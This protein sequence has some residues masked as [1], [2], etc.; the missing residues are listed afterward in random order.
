MRSRAIPVCPLGI[1][2]ILTLLSLRCNKSRLGSLNRPSWTYA[3]WR[4]LKTPGGR[5]PA[6]N[7]PHSET[8][9][10]TMKK[11]TLALGLVAA[12]TGT[13]MAATRPRARVVF[14]MVVS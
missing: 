4:D 14:F 10:T 13:V 5:F 6:Q 2:G 3:S 11:T 1:H 9:E 7:H 8:Q 12:L